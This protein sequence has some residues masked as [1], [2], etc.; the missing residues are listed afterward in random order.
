[1]DSYSIISDITD[2]ELSE[3]IEIKLAICFTRLENKIN[4]LNKDEIKDLCIKQ[5]IPIKGKLKIQELKNLIIGYIKFIKILKP[6]PK[7][8][9]RNLI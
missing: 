2:S 5:N 7:F 4:S 9:I 3:N 8:K 6:L 1:M